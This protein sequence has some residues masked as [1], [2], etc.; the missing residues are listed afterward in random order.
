M[1]FRLGQS[2]DETSSPS[3]DPVTGVSSGNVNKT[4]QN[5]FSWQNDVRTAIG[6]FM[7]SADF[8]VEKVAATAAFSVTNR[9]SRSLVAGY[10]GNF[11]AHSLQASG[12]IDDIS[13]LGSHRSGTLAYG[14]ELSPHWRARA[15]AGTAFHAPTFADLY[16]PADPVFLYTG[17]PN[18]KPE[19]ARNK[20]LGLAYTADDA[21]AS[22]THFRNRVGDLLDFVFV[23]WPGYSY[24]GNVSSATL[25]GTE[26][27]ASYAP[28]S[29]TLR[30]NYSLLHARNDLN[31]R[32]LQGRAARTGM[33]EVRRRFEALDLGAQVQG[34][35]SRFNDS[36]N[37]TLL[38]GYA[39]LN[40]DARYRIGQGWSLLAKV[41]N[42]LDRRYEL[43]RMDASYFDFT[44]FTTQSLFN[45]VNTPGANLFVALRYAP[46]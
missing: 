22:L 46:K 14:Y 7:A 41:N 20:E 23:P 16:W 30:G 45:R 33:I 32:M 5:Q 27:Q 36:A 31:G 24:M 17:N 13:R 9:T 25:K 43:K 38:G 34:A 37:G 28:G 21:Q 42:V 18:L 8:R 29:W 39:L 2:S 12:R 6:L 15:S 10:Q 35:S 1:L 4:T 11:G 44:T 19:R 26:F 40:L 3:F